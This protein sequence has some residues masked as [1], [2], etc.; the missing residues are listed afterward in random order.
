MCENNEQKENIC[1]DHGR[2]DNMCENHGQKKNMRE[3]FGERI[4]KLKGLAKALHCP[5]RWDIIDIIGSGEAKTKEIRK[6]MKERNYELSNP[7]LYYH[8]S[9]LK[10]AGVIEV[11]DYVEEGR[12]AP[13]KKWK[14]T[15]EK[16]EI[17]LV[18]SGE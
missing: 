14:L 18:D 11:S 13:E 12:G 4:R 7:G 5:T 2:N 1:E 8:L 16:I 15:R 6:G 10:D 17:D 3:K 9:E